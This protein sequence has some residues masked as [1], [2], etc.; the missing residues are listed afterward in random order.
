M[1]NKETAPTTAPKPEAAHLPASTRTAGV[2]SWNR[3]LRFRLTLW[4][5]GILAVLLLLGAW[6]LYTGAQR[7]LLA[8]TD[9]FLMREARRITA[10]AAGSPSDVPDV[11]DLAEA[12]ASRPPLRPSGILPSP[13]GAPRH[14][15][16]DLLF[17]DV[18][19]TRLVRKEAYRP[20]VTS[21]DLAAQ[22][23][24]ERSLDPLLREPSPALGRYSFAGPDEEQT[25]RVLTLPGRIGREAGLLQVAVPWDHNADVLERLAALLALVLPVVLLL[26][27]AGGW[28]LVGRT[29]QPISRIVAEAERLDASALP[30]ALLPEAGES[31]SEIGRL[32]ATLNRMTTRLRKAFEAQTHFAEAQQRFAADASHELRTPLTILRGEMEL[33][34]TRPR[35]RA[36]YEATLA[37]AVEE[38]DRMSRIVEGLSF[39]ARQNAGALSAANVSA[40]PVGTTINLATLSDLVIAEFEPRAREAGLLLTRERSPDGQERV[41]E[42]VPVIRGNT[43]QLYLL[44]RNL[45]DNAL[46]YTDAGGRVTVSTQVSAGTEGAT[47]DAVVTVQ[48][49]GA[50]IAAG[51]LPHIFERFWRADRARS[52]GGSGLGLSICAQIAEAH[53]GALTVDSQLGSGSCFHLRLPLAL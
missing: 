53:G 45:V 17:F 32:V 43:D 12:I 14:D 37:S 26:A 24:V 10:L 4:Y 3:S 22:P 47:G 31:D 25:V 29:L 11:S 8:E 9:A 13:S 49:T 6:L 27:A 35:E 21:A 42:P 33:A 7:A 30:E 46:K 39:L 44:L 16:S 15:N 28:V 51:D 34:L 2:L 18:V 38:I 5:T 48:D 19:Y 41:G 52:T 20:L 40:D 1:S 36:V 23:A 50:G